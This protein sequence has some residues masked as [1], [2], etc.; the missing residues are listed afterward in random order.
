MKSKKVS[1]VCL[2]LSLSLFVELGLGFTNVQAAENDNVVTTAE[3]TESLDSIIDTISEDVSV[4]QEGV[5]LGD[6][7]TILENINQED[8]NNLNAL[9]EQ[10]GIEYNQPLTKES[11]VQMFENGIDTINSEV[12]DG[13]LEVLSDG[14]LIES[15]DEDFYVQGG[16]TYDKTYWWGRKRYKSTANANKWASQLNSVGNANAAGAVVAGAVFGGV[17]AIPNGLTAA[18]AYQLQN[19]VSYRNSLN[20]RGIVANLTWALVFTVKSQ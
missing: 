6:K 18:Y 7:S 12:E 10:Q 19:K 2:L 13:N 11:V 8:I 3:G 9:A 20:K 4:D 15:D 16:S 1:I 14:S 5:E 17:G